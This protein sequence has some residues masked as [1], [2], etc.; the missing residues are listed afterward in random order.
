MIRFGMG[1]KPTPDG[2][3]ALSLSMGDKRLPGIDPAR[4]ASLPVVR[5]GRSCFAG[6]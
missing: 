2:T 3:L 1:P 6:L 4:V 5:P